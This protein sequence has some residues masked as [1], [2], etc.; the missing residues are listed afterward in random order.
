MEFNWTT[1]ALEILNFLVLIWI[2]QRFLYKPV[3]GAIARRKA[4]IDKTVDDARK[5]ETEAA[6]LKQRYEHRLDEWAREQEKARAQ[7]SEEIAADR[8]RAF[9]ALE[10][11]LAQEK[12]KNRVLE[13]RR[14]AEFRR[15]ADDAG[16]T[17]GRQ[18]AA[19]LLSRLASPE[20]ERRILDVLLEDLPL[21]GDTDLHALRA[22]A[23]GSDLRI[24]VTSAYPLAQEGRELLVQALGR[25]LGQPVDCAFD[26]DGG[27][28]AGF[29]VKIG[30]WALHANLRDELSFFAEASLHAR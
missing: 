23:A 30:P 8:R 10:T 2:L 5:V 17:V 1:F 18:F 25:M 22:S 9:A 7:L 27:L 20:M 6:V 3:L 28:H 26:E 13:E 15:E 19:R 16:R 24:T 14:E 12:E 21:V 29:Q 11:S 4:A